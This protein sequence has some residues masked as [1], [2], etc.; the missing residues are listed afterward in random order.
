[1]T[2]TLE[3]SIVEGPVFPTLTNSEIGS[4]RLEDDTGAV[5]GTCE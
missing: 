2:S 3:F 5:V 1:M 4:P